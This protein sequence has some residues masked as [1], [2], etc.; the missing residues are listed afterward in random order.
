MND[1]QNGDSLFG[2][3]KR[4]IFQVNLAKRRLFTRIA[5]RYHNQLIFRMNH[6]VF[7]VRI[8]V[9]DTFVQVQG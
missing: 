8:Q 5:V 7:R 6:L 2:R 1:V 9:Q 4:Q 3:R